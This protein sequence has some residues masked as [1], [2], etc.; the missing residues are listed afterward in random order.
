MP[1][2]SKDSDADH[3]RA[4]AEEE[5]RRQQVLADERARNQREAD[6]VERERDRG[7]RP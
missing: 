4:A 5:R 2:Y 1:R 7:S 6:R 3:G